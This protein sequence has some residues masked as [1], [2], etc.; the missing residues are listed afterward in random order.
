MTRTWTAPAVFGAFDGLTSA[1][2]VMPALV[3]HPSVALPAAIGV[4]T[5]EAVGMAAGQ[6]Q[7]DSQHGVGAAAVIGVAT[8]AGTILPALPFAFARGGVALA[9][10]VVLM[11]TVVAVIARLRADARGTVRAATES[12]L[13]LAAAVVAVLLIHVLTPGES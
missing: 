11:L 1:I 8:G 7:S 5:A 3:G 6:W 13:I 9:V 4:G 10:S 2:G 12:Y